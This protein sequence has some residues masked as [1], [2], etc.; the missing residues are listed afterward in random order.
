MTYGGNIGIGSTFPT[1]KLDVSGN[2]NST[3]YLIKNLNISNIFPT[4]N[5]LT[6]TSNNLSSFIIANDATVNTRI[7]NN[8]NSI[9]TIINNSYCKKTTFYFT[10]SN[11]YNYNGTTYYTY[12]IQISKFIKY[13][14]LD[15]NTSLAKFRIHTAPF[16]SYFNGSE[17]RECEY[18]IMI[19]NITT[20]D[21]KNGLN[22]RAIGTPQDAYLQKIQPWKIVKSANY[23]YITYISPIQNSII[24]CT[25]IDEG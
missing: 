4:S 25:M 19:S 18:L 24:L 20:N 10:T 13:L 17:I 14:N 6:S 3:E 16:D 8:S 7:S 12:N 22:V 1:Q 15:A 21:Y 9:T 2:T 23:D 5:V 11:P